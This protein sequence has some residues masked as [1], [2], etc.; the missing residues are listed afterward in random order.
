[1][2][3]RDE[4]DVATQY[5]EPVTELQASLVQLWTEHLGVAPIGIHDDFF[6]LGG[7]SLLAAELQLTIEM[8]YD[9]EIPA[10]VLFRQPTIGQLAKVIDA[11]R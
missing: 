6:E 1:M 8:R 5:A 3:T 7:H 4:L 11:D 2:M 9:V 10:W